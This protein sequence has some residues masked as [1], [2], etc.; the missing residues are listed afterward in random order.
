VRLV[1]QRRESGRKDAFSMT[2]LDVLLPV[3]DMDIIE[4][5]VSARLPLH[6]LWLEPNPDLWLAEWA[7]RIRALAIV[8]KHLPVDEA[9]MRRF[10]NLEIISNFGAATTISRPMRRHGL[11]SS[12]PT[13]R[14]CLTTKLPTRRSASRS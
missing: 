11:E 14:A 7:P 4:E 9:Y 2:S 1:R 5:E 3:K 12:S 6:R 10:P 13:R 8:A